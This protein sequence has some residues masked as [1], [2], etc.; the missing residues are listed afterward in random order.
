LERKLSI[1][2][3]YADAL[4]QAHDKCRQ[5]GNHVETSSEPSANYAQVC[6]LTILSVELSICL[7]S[8]ISRNVKG[9]LGCAY[10]KSILPE[11]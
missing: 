5:E 4:K 11:A 6:L 9:R 8:G 2:Q 3:A 1:S 10:S 7:I